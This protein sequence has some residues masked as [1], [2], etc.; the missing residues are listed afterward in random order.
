MQM[1]T[2]R[3]RPWFIAVL[4][5][6]L[7]ALLSV[8]KG[9]D[10]NWDL[11]NYHRY[12][13]HAY[14]H[15]RL[16]LD[17]APAGMQ[18]Y[19]NP[20]LDIPVYW[21]SERWPGWVVGAAIGA[22]HGLVFVFTWLTVCACWP[23]G[24]ADLRLLVAA[25]GVLAPV[26]WGGL[27]NTMGDN[28][29]AVFVLAAVWMA[30]RLCQLAPSVQP[31]RVAGMAACIGLLLGLATALKL[32]QVT[33]SLA[34]VLVLWW[35]LGFSAR[36]GLV[37]T[38]LVPAGLIGV[39]LGGG[40]W[41]WQV[42]QQ[43]GNPFFPQFGT[44]FPSPLADGVSIVDKRFVPESVLGFVLRPVLM[45]LRPSVTSEFFV[46]PLLW[47]AWFGAGV[48]LLWRV[49]RQRVTA[50]TAWT[51]A[52]SLVLGFVL[53]A[54]ML[55]AALF[56]I[57]RYTAAMEPLLPLC[58]LLLAHRAGWLARG[59]R[60]LKRFL[61]LSMATA[62]LGGAVNWG[63]TAWAEVTYRPA[64]PMVVEGQRPLVIA[65]GNAQSW[66]IPFLPG[67]ARYTSLGGSLDFG[68]PFD[69]AVQKRAV[70]SD[71]IYAIVGMSQ[72][73]R[74]DVVDKANGALDALGLL[75]QAAA[76]QGL[77]LL[78]RRTRVHAGFSRCEGASCLRRCEL[79]KLSTDQDEVDRRD[80]RDFDQAKRVLGGL[81][82]GL[83]S[84]RCTTEGAYIGQ[85]RY[86]FRLCE[87][88]RSLSQL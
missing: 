6:V 84:E 3:P 11:L 88:A 23:S 42:W 30:V 18:S 33:M 4:G 1:D 66:L 75:N 21:M 20:T 69:A 86:P 56:G 15:D 59:E 36:A 85:K 72:N 48:W 34:L 64:S 24:R 58:I 52:Q 40:W 53:F 22:W 16:A 87:L 65:V 60:W 76:C 32:T 37:L 39:C 19:F 8:Y 29:A 43:F 70:E 57:Y 17:L 26:F 38:S 31:G 62:L 83:A 78:L 10:T 81:G 5:V 82:L 25:A 2:L 47:P 51:P 7:A 54:S 68:R 63:H 12:V 71:R 35:Q 67:H 55:W 9:Q 44:L 41:F 77:E 50:S 45:L 61:A 49:L 14:F 13:A 74:F 28:A 46:L 27:G 79:T 80:A 73:W